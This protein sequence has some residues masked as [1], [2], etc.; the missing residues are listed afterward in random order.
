MKI[1]IV[2]D[3][4]EKRRVIT[5]VA[6]SVA[7]IN[8]ECITYA[9]DAWTAKKKIKE[10]RFDLVIL[11]INI[12]RTADGTVVVG[13]GTEVLRFIKNN[14]QAQSPRFLFGLTAFDDGYEAAS[15]EFSSP[16]W[17]LV[18]FAFGNSA[19][20]A[21]LREAFEFLAQSDRPPFSTDGRTFRTDVC[22]VVA[23]EDVELAG[24]LTGM[25]I[26]WHEERV[27]HDHT[28]YYRGA[29]RMEGGVVSLIAA[30]APRMG[31][32][33][34]AS[35][36]TKLI[37]T[38]RPAMVAMAGIC[39]GVRGKVELGDILIADPCFDWGSGKWAESGEELE[40][41]PAAYQWRLDEGTRA[42]AKSLSRMDKSLSDMHAAY[43][44][45]KPRHAPRVHIEA[46]ASGGAVLQSST[47]MQKV[48]SLHKNLIGIEMESYAVFTACEYSSEPRPECISVKSVC[49]FGDE[50]KSD[51][52]HKYAAYTSAAF[53][54]E[55]I[56]VRF[57]REHAEQ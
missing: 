35:I 22:I 17:K 11:D 56:R 34:A 26:D 6:R 12:P 55:I 37:N 7:G 4:H 36:T 27:P 51:G 5:E 10:E 25:G 52:F 16:L 42:I 15:A 14:A 45:E 8:Q 32:A 30:A 43:K 40:F 9:G 31:M 39:A 33:P 57:R 54:S 20:R 28:V 49:D 44:A 47:T 29:I 3:E 21:T 2:D 18:K 48:R 1:L 19:W 53:L 13:A 23:L 46:M 50:A 38:F 41:L 24:V